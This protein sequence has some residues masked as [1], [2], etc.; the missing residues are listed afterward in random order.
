[1]GVF[2]GV[3]GGDEAQIS[4]L[5][6]TSLKSL[7]STSSCSETDIPIFLFLSPKSDYSPDPTTGWYVGQNFQAGSRKAQQTGRGDEE[8]AGWCH[9]NKLLPTPWDPPKLTDYGTQVSAQ[10]NDFDLPRYNV[11]VTP[12]SS[13]QTHNSLFRFSGQWPSAS[14]VPLCPCVSSF[15]SW[16][17]RSVIVRRTQKGEASV[18]LSAY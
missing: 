15:P 8:T 13:M 7:T 9:L 18:E 11:P 16:R 6:I 2:W 12:T 1:M 17:R 5:S 10:E 4:A 14:Q 3:T